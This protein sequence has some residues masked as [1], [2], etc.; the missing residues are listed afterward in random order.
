VTTALHSTFPDIQAYAEKYPFFRPAAKRMVDEWEKG[1]AA[2][3]PTANSR[4]PPPGDVRASLGMSDVEPGDRKVNAY[5]NLDG[6]FSH[7]AR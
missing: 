5:K 1:L 4:V 6:A 3:Q 2:I 7:K